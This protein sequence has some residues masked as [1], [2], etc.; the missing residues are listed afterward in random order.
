MKN[1]SFYISLIFFL[2]V[3]V[4]R[5]ILGNAKSS[6]IFLFI[7][8]LPLVFPHDL[9]FL[10]PFL[11]LSYTTTSTTFA[12]L[13]QQKLQQHNPKKY[14]IINFINPKKLYISN[15]FINNLKEY[16]NNNFI[17]PKSTTAIIGFLIPIFGTPCT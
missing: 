4:T 15:S 14:Y 3:K 10:F 13:Q 12:T 2:I 9:S 6:K 11:P 1:I 8:F 17:N 5:N 16:Y 7:L